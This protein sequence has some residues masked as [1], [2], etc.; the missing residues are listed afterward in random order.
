[1]ITPTVMAPTPQS[2]FSTSKET[3]DATGTYVDPGMKYHI[4]DT[5]HY[6][7]NYTNTDPSFTCTL[8]LWDRLPNGTI[9]DF[10]TGAYF[11]IGEKKTFHVDYVVEAGD[12]RDPTGL[13]DYK[14]I[15]NYGR[16]MGL[17]SNSDVIDDNRS[18]TSEILAEPPELD[19]D[20][21][22]ACCKNISF[23]GGVV[24]GDVV[25]H[26]WYFGDGETET[27]AGE[28]GETD[29]VYSS[30][31]PYTVKLSG[32]NA[33]GL[34][35][36]V[37]DEIYVDRDPTAVITM[38]PQSC[39]EKDGTE[40][41]FSGIN[42]KPD[43]D[44]RALL[45]IVKYEWTFTDESGTTT[46]NEVEV[47][48]TVNDDL[49]AT[50]TVWSGLDADTLCCNDTAT[51]VVGPCSQCSLRIYGTFGEGPGN[52]D[53]PCENKP[54]TDPMGPFYP[55]HEQAP[56]K[57]FIT[58][59][60]AIMPNNG[61]LL[62]V[63]LE[64]PG[65]NFYECD[66][67]KI[68]VEVPYEK[69]FKRMWYE[70][71]WFKDLPNSDNVGKWDVLVDTPDGVEVRTLEGD[72]EQME[73]MAHGEFIREWNNDPTTGAD[74]YGPALIQEFT[75]MFL[76]EDLMPAMIGAE[77]FVLIPMASESQRGDGLD[78]FDAD[79]DDDFDYVEVTNEEKLSNDW[80]R[81]GIEDEMTADIDRDHNLD[82]FGDGVELSGDEEFILRL[83][84]M[85][86]F[87][88]DTLQFFDHVVTLES[89]STSGRA[90]FTVCDN[91]GGGT[92]TCSE[93][94]SLGINE[95]AYFYRGIEPTP[96]PSEKSTFYLRLV[97]Y[98]TEPGVDSTTVEVGRIFGNTY[99]NIGNDPQWNQ[100]AFMVDGVLYEV[101]AIK[102]EGNCIKY[103]TFRQK[104]PKAPYD[105]K[106]Y[107]KELTVWD[108][109][110]PLPEMPPFNLDHN[111]LVDV[112]AG[113]D[114]DTEE[115]TWTHDKIGV[116]KE[117]PPLMIDY[118]AE[119][120]ELRYLGELKE[121]YKEKCLKTNDC[122]MDNCMSGC[123]SE[124][125]EKMCKDLCCVK[126]DEYWELEWF[127]TLPWQYTELRL[128]KDDKYLVTL[129]WKAPESEIAI[130][131]HN[132][133][134]DPEY[135]E[136]ERFK[137]WYEDCSG[138][139]Y[140]DNETSS[141]RLYGWFDEGPGKVP[142][143]ILRPENKPY[144]DPM[145]PF[146]PQHKQAPDK[147]FI[148]FNPAIMDH[149]QG[150]PEL[151]YWV[152]DSG[153]L[154]VQRPKEKV[155]KRMWYEKDWFKDLPNS[156]NVGKW[157]VLVDTPTGVE[158]W[159]MNKWKQMPFWEKF[160]NG[161]TIREWNNDATLGA[162]IYG[163][164]INQEFTYM[165]LDDATMPI[166]IGAESFVLIP[167]A[168][169]VLG[170]G[171]DSFDAD[172]DG[173][174]DA[175]EV[176]NEEM[177]WN[178]WRREGIEDEMTAD[179]DRDHNLDDFGDS[180][181]LNGD[182][183]F[184]LRLDNM[185]LFAGK[186]LQ[187]FDHVVTLESVSASGNA[188]FTVCDNE[189][190]GTPTC[191]EH[192]SLSINDVKYFYRGIEPTPGPSEKST[193]YL[194][195]IDY[196]TEPGVDSALVEVGRIFGNTYA[197]IG[198]DPQWNQKAFMVDGVLY[199]VVAIK[200]EGKCIKY[201]TFRQKLPKAPYDIKLYGKELVTWD[202]G[203]VLPE[204]PPFNMNHEILDDVQ[205]TWTVPYSQQD[206]IGEKK[207]VGPLNIT[208]IEEDVEERFAGE[209]KEI[210]TEE[211]W[212][213]DAVGTAG[214]FDN[215]H[216]EYWS[217][218]WFFTQPWQ[219]TSFVL[220]DDQLYLVTLAWI[221]PEA[222]Y[223]IWDHKPDQHPECKEGGRVKFWYGPDS[224][225]RTTYADLYVNR[226]G[227]APP[228][229]TVEDY[230]GMSA[231][232]GNGDEIIDLNE[233]VNAIMDYLYD[234]H[235]FGADGPFDIEELKGYLSAWLTQE[236]Y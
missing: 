186:S 194:R 220:P 155:F 87:P 96:G 213:G 29:H 49:T 97:D 187:F 32:T 58:F 217:V 22:P 61:Q 218:E 12:V 182:E 8:D 5:V 66:G 10:A 162:D 188:R 227:P 121:I 99:A 140:I 138:P 134:Q 233:L 160:E 55:Q 137:F 89:V 129:S 28:P 156:D 24:S 93:H 152:C 23:S 166:M 14:H 230:Y 158:V 183:E 88:G 132:P 73:W 142:E 154:D 169:E 149:N 69:V 211:C 117:M 80:R 102:A 27:N 131:D 198:N 223:A 200:A 104:L 67:D 120:I 164:A 82:D 126:E 106:L 2:D 216:D 108:E 100:K 9:V 214:S 212:Q 185:E 116:A 31:G 135:K 215:E 39:Y 115:Y 86:L 208:Y 222:G 20:W 110:V 54:Y 168:S 25:T 56:R 30:G 203:V 139:I 76:G 192:R 112:Q 60:P 15:V 148:T 177:L 144:T 84:N 189:G 153:K 64:Y 70:K 45:G 52:L 83:D 7:V 21:E 53:V 17:N 193:F 65:L 91:E 231:H 191:S 85:E 157:D 161:Y 42:S 221:A 133:D 33:A 145:G 16:A 74:I 178:D 90:R 229:L 78:S 219:Y 181:E 38:D 107:G 236:G 6:I 41:T 146:D 46:S 235:P 48:K 136:G 197:N 18:K 113:Y 173:D 34:E 50:L 59:N 147:D 40:I 165:F 47:T 13:I 163:P 174:R 175:V 151:N 101:V 150:Y 36:S 199:N 63:D 51:K 57:D 77:S 75:Y 79:G 26:T 19:F 44:S 206:K 11:A 170:N 196:D 204:M 68:D 72:W 180:I 224:E 122:C 190:G 118:I 3:L 167:M 111:I 35:G 201:I 119:D 92:P 124:D 143:D 71:D 94:R 62:D 4:G 81:E 207:A 37:T 114:P 172:G 1:V 98:D 195:L 209:L 130:W 125:C 202:E 43:Q 228:E 128:P 123:M 234:G 141:I 171:L 95:V 127:L 109:R 232:G 176:T 205:N 226:V 103:I 105:I 179:I 225:V 184:I 159:T 210:Y